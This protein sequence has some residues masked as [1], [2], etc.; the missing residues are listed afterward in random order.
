MRQKQLPLMA[1]NAV[2]TP[3]AL[4]F[5]GLAAYPGQMIPS[6]SE[7]ANREAARMNNV[8]ANYVQI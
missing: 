3:G 8:V 5:R 4:P 7:I 6:R 1:H 2:V